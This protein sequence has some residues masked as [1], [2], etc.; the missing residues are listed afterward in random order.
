MIS[1]VVVTHGQLARELVTAAE[2]IVGDLPHVTSV[3]VGWHDDT[4]VIHSE[5]EKAIAKVQVGDGVLILTDM[6]GGTPSNVALTFLEKSRVEIITGVN[7]PMLLK[8][9]QQEMGAD[10]G[11]VAQAVMAQGKK[12]ITLASEV[13]HR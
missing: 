9:S 12:N 6:F 11:S 3:S 4:T 2:M 1:A 8:L 10:I 13:L 7:L 5:I